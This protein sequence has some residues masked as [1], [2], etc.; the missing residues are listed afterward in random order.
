MKIITSLKHVRFMRLKINNFV[1]YLYKLLAK[2]LKEITCT[3]YFIII[4]TSIIIKL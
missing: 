3:Q 1:M 4:Q 2:G